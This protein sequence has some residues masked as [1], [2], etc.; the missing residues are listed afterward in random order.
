MSSGC[1]G[2]GGTVFR[3]VCLNCRPVVACPRCAGSGWVAGV[4]CRPCRGIG[5]RP[6]PSVWTK[7]EV[8]AAARALVRP[9]PNES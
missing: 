4:V 8:V 6:A 5:E 3:G 2:C 7:L 9:G 1:G